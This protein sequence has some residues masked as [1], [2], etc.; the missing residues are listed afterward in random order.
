MKTGAIDQNSFSTLNQIRLKLQRKT[1]KNEPQKKRYKKDTS[2]VNAYIFVS[3]VSLNHKYWQNFE[4]IKKIT[5]DQFKKT[6]MFK[7]TK[8]QGLL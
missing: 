7:H 4:R 5:K 8:F 6:S 1:T 3:Y 2:R